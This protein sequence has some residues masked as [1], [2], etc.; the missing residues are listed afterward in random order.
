MS[1]NEFLTFL[2]NLSILAFFGQFFDGFER[3]IGILTKIK[4]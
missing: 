1:K 3:Q 4:N 2:K